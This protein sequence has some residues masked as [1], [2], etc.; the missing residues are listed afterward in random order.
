MNRLRSRK[1][2]KRKQQYFSFVS[3]LTKD[4]LNPKN[5]NNLVYVDTP[6]SCIIYEA[7]L[8]STEYNVALLLHSSEHFKY[9]DIVKVTGDETRGLLTIRKIITNASKLRGKTSFVF[10]PKVGDKVV[11]FQ[12]GKRGRKTQGVVCGK[13]GPKIH[14]QFKDWAGGDTRIEVFYR[15]T[16]EYYGNI[17]T[18][19]IFD[20]YSVFSEEFVNSWKD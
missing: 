20:Y 13:R 9:G 19:G 5:H 18:C 11:L 12:D 14:V 15:E 16:S 2:G 8:L 17:D 7:V 6:H 1:R 3:S 4:I 10:N